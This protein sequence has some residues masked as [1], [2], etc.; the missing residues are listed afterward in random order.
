M[1]FD[2]SESL[3][4]PDS[5][6][7]DTLFADVPAESLG[8]WSGL[9]PDCDEPESEPEGI[10]AE[11]EATELGRNHSLETEPAFGGDWLLLELVPLPGSST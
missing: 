2:G 7:P 8:F 3:E 1:L 9:P 6:G 10:P 11:H 4:E 5:L